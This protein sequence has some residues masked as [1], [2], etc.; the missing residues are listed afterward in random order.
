MHNLCSRAH[1]H[2]RALACPCLFSMFRHLCIWVCSRLSY[3]ARAHNPALTMF[4]VL[5]K[6]YYKWFIH[7][8]AAFSLFWLSLICLLTRSLARFVVAIRV[9]FSS[10]FFVIANILF[11]FF[12]THFS[13]LNS[14]L[15]VRLWYVRMCL[16][17]CNA[18]T[19]PNWWNMTKKK[20][21]IYILDAH[22]HRA[23]AKN[24]EQ[25]NQRQQQQPLET[26]TE[27]RR[28]GMY[29]EAMK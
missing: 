4:R 14:S 10:G 20:N 24:N 29:S 17:E 6:S 8:L 25:K 22:I 23:K 13:T 27:K 5:K 28:R 16:G 21:Q 1:T 12:F 15:P 7:F 3:W 2:T 11:Y 19:M 26:T 18:Q 9:C